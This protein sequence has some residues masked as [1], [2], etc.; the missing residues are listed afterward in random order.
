MLMFML[1]EFRNDVLPN[2]NEGFSGRFTYDYSRR[3]LVEVNFG[4]NGTERLAKG[5]RFELFPAVSLGWVASNEDWWSV[6]N[7]YIDHLKIRG[8]Y[9]LVGSDETG[10]LAGAAHFLYRNEVNLNGGGSFTTGPYLGREL[11]YFALGTCLSEICCGQCWVER[12]QKI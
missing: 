4:Y 5:H 9:G 7:P 6:I 3:Y 12:S 1:R 2:R 10:L 8:S 11:D